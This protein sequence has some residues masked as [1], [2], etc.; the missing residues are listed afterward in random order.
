M[1]YFLP[2]S[3]WTLIF[4]SYFHQS[5][6]FPNLIISKFATFVKIRS[7]KVYQGLLI[8]SQENP[9]QLSL[10][11][12]TVY[13]ETS[14]LNSKLI[15]SFPTYKLILTYNPSVKFL[16]QTD[17]RWINTEIVTLDSPGSSLYNPYY[18]V[19]T[20]NQGGIDS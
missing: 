4:R 13:K 7:G 16:S 14:L 11:Y 20:A 17:V 5:F 12:V 18:H 15:L 6:I 3:G 9:R 2:K 1:Q 19:T 8:K 10:L